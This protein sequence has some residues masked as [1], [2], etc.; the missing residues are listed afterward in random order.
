MGAQQKKGCQP[1]VSTRSW[2]V[3]R[4]FEV[5]SGVPGTFLAFSFSD[6]ILLLNRSRRNISVS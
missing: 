6:N 1:M 4:R 3:S 2:R 5:V